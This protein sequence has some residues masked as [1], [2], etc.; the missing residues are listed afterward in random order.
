MKKIL[1]MVLALVMVCAATVSAAAFPDMQ[2]TRW[3]W[4]R[5]TVEKLVN[6]GII[7]GYSDGT[8]KPENNVTNEEA[9][10]LF[11]RVIGV[12]DPANKKAVADA[13]VL[14]KNIAEKYVTY[15]S[16]ELCF[17]LYRGILEPSD[18]DDYLAPAVQDVPMK[19]YEAAKLIT[20][21]MGGEQEAI[22]ATS[23]A[24]N[25]A[26]KNDFPKDAGGYINYVSKQGIM[27]G[28]G[29]GTFSANT[30]VTRAQVAVMLE[31]TINKLK[32]SYVMGKVED[33]TAD[34]ITVDGDLYGLKAETIV[35]RDGAKATVEALES[36][37]DV[38]LVKTYQGLLA[39]DA[40]QTEE[41]E[42]NKKIVEG[43]YRG[44]LTDS[45]G[46]FV[47]VYDKE[48]GVNTTE[49][50]LL[51]EET[52]SYEVN[53]E[54]R[55][56]LSAILET[57]YVYLTIVSGQ[58]VHIKAESKYTQISNATF[59]KLV[60]KED[61]NLLVIGHKDAI[62]D[63]TSWPIAENIVVKRNAKDAKVTDLLAG[64]ALTLDFTYGEI[65]KITATSKTSTV[66]GTLTAIHIEREQPYIEVKLMDDTLKTI[67]MTLDTKI[68]IDN[69]ERTIYD[70]I[71][72]YTV[73][74]NTESSA[75]SKITVTSVAQTSSLTGTVTVVN[76]QLKFLMIDVSDTKTNTVKAYQVFVGDK[77]SVITGSNGA[78][79]KL[80]S[81]AEGDS[82]VIAGAEKLG[83]FEANTI[84]I[85][86]R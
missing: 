65:T 85:V 30:G 6:T 32:L 47:K 84:V 22:H 20:K 13:Q 3:D 64:D 35:H 73:A 67:Y 69:L 81:I 19:R 25:Y 21:V 18:L 43:I 27:A 29:D 48:G 9:F 55:V 79:V 12:N 1:A 52:V 16:K 83:A 44:S 50:Y 78:K 74:I 49:T 36:G 53:G 57:D 51:S 82:I 26:D 45:R 24:I 41:S 37:D 58:V 33:V 5:E 40:V 11:A 61:K 77:T 23:F 63:T 42:G 8:Y 4:A 2:D 46:T 56:S 68:L 15:A 86:N 54:E 17:L 80:S 34:S 31:R 14:Y 60:H 10:T 71:L 66:K 7:K 59:T 28:M 39:I 75:A 76:E 70:L 38:T 72:G 62:Y